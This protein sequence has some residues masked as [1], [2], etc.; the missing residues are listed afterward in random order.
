MQTHVCGV[1]G[2]GEFMWV[3]AHVNHSSSPGTASAS[4]RCWLSETHCH[5]HTTAHRHTCLDTL[6]QTQ[7]CTHKGKHTQICTCTYKHVHT[8]GCLHTCTHRH[9]GACMEAA[10]HVFT[11]TPSVHAQ[12]RGWILPLS[13][14]SPLSTSC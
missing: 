2:G 10:L 14:L 6:A 12:A 3:C 9:T 5:T 8:H 4:V 7:T 13:S 1:G 11:S